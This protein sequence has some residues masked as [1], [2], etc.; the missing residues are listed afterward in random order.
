MSDSRRQQ[1]AQAVAASAGF[2]GFID[3]HR[4]LVW[5]L[6][7]DLVASGSTRQHAVFLVL[8]VLLISASF[9]GFAGFVGFVGCARTPAKPVLSPAL[10]ATILALL[11]LGWF[12]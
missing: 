7:S 5:F 12:T 8:L 2:A 3:Q 11:V 1:H 10:L 9:A 6:G 4:F